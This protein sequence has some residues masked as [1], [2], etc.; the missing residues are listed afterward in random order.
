MQKNFVLI[1]IFLPSFL[2][3]Q[4]TTQ[5]TVKADIEQYGSNFQQIISSTKSATDAATKY[6]RVSILLIEICI[7]LYE[8]SSN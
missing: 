8:S 3:A 6:E 7:L 5:Q 1:I 4:T 2:F